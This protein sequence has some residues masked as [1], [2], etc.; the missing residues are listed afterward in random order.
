MLYNMIYNIIWRLNMGNLRYRSG[1][2]SKS[3]ELKDS[4]AKPRLAIR[5]SSGTK[6]LTLKAGVRS[7]EL[8]VRGASTN[9][10]VK[11]WGQDIPEFW[12]GMSPEEPLR[13]MGANRG[14]TSHGGIGV[15]LLVNEE[16]YPVVAFGRAGADRP[17]EWAKAIWYP[18]VEGTDLVTRFPN[19]F[20]LT[21]EQVTHPKRLKPNIRLATTPS[22]AGAS[23]SEVQ[24][25]TNSSVPNTLNGDRFS[26]RNN[27]IMAD[28]ITSLTTKSRNY[29]GYGAYSY[30]G[31][32][33]NSASTNWVTY[34]GYGYSTLNTRGVYWPSGKEE[35]GAGVS[36]QSYNGVGIDSEG[37]KV[38]SPLVGYEKFFNTYNY[39][40]SNAYR[41]YTGLTGNQGSP[42]IQMYGV[43]DASYNKCG[44]WAQRD[45]YIEFPYAWGEDTNPNDYFTF[46]PKQLLNAALAIATEKGVADHDYGFARGYN[47]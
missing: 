20:R 1:S 8:G 19:N 9:Y 16:N 6:Y 35:Q 39:S 30:Y 37:F 43:G 3:Y 12:R 38:D 4:S 40:Y 11:T 32:S 34:Y 7:G 18:S 28:I 44:N 15:W 2:V 5:T 31:G 26:Y 29:V 45:F 41:I 36:D 22:S 14:D 13:G 10:Y 42:Y 23:K 25:I 27:I 21:A 46:T 47:Y 17:D 33:G 24:Q